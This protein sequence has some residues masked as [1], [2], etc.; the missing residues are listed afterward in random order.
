MLVIISYP[1]RYAVKMMVDGFIFCCDICES[2]RWRCCSPPSSTPR[3]SVPPPRGASVT[4]AADHEVA[5]NGAKNG[6]AAA[7]PK[8][9]I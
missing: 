3:Q 6:A 4:A 1:G 5:K 2:S 9:Y 8:D 7:S